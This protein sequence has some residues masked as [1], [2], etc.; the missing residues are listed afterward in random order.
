MLHRV[1]QFIQ[2][3]SAKVL[4]QDHVFIKKY[5][6]K[7]E[8]NLFYQLR[9]SEQRHSLNV[10]YGCQSEAPENTNL[11]R[12]ALLHDIGKVG[13]N[14]TLL[15]KSFVVMTIKLHLKENILPSYLKKALYYKYHH[16]AIGFEML[17]NLHIEKD[18]LRLVRDHHHPNNEYWDSMSILKRYDDLY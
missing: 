10:A 18:V 4:E 16:A 12:G 17:K 1:K 15:N 14:L 13:S 3:L 5:L 2:G 11:I 6:S 8:S 7:Q 9:I